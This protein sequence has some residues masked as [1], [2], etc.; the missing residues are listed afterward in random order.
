VLHVF[1]TTAKDVFSFYIT[2]LFKVKIIAIIHDVSSLSNED[3][4]AYRKKMYAMASALVVHNETSYREIS[5]VLTAT[6]QEKLHIIPHGNYIDFV[7]KKNAMEY[8]RDTLLFDAAYKYLLF[9]GQIKK[10]KGLDVLLKAMALLPPDYK[11]IIAG[12]PHRDDFADY[13]HI[14]DELQFKDRIIPF[15]RFI[16]DEERDYLFK[17]CDALI[18]P[19][20]KIFQSGVLL[21]SMSYGLPV[22]ASDLPANKEIIED[23][24]NGMLFED[25]NATALAQK[26]IGLFA[27]TNMEAIKSR[28]KHTAATRFSWSMIAPAYQQI[29]DLEPQAI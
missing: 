5:R 11:L 25:G 12:R 1:S 7:S 2:R 15:I 18:L 3:N 26:I 27:N 29:M 8:F 19:Y 21:L 20:R 14:I 17:R 24:E 10:V 4:P 28:T 13:Q 6:D 22:V 23:G 16:T 9:F